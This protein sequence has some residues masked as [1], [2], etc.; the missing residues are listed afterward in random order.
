MWQIY[1]K[2]FDLRDLGKFTD[3]YHRRREMEA[4]PASDEH[5]TL[6]ELLRSFEIFGQ[7]VDFFAF[8]DVGYD[9][10]RVFAD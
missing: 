1:R 2:K 6:R 4:N 8:K 3:H 5:N 10:Q 9:L 7:I